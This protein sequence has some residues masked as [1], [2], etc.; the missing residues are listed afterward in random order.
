MHQGNTPIHPHGLPEAQGLY[1]PSKEHDACGLGLVAH[2]KGVKS[3]GIV[4]DGLKVLLNLEH[5]GAVGADPHAGDGAGILVQLPHEFLGAEAERL[6]FKL[7]APGTYGVGQLFLPQ[8]A[9]M[10]AR[11][12]EIV[13]KV[14]AEEDMPLLGWR[15]VPVNNESLPE[16]VIA[17]RTLPPAGIRWQAGAHRR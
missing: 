1:Q 14:L 2:I 5:R 12:E 3:H 13:A 4:Q 7:P 11:C 9:G 8:D 15:E 17:D 16:I 10:R 6:G